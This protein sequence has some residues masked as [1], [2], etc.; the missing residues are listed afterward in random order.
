MLETN[1]GLTSRF[2]KTIIF[3]D[4]NAEQLSEIFLNKAKKDRLTLDAEAEKAMRSYF[5]SLCRNKGRNFG[6]AREVNNY[7]AK[8][9][10]NQSAR[11]RKA[12]ELPDFDKMMFCQLL[13]ED[14]LI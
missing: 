8:V 4:Y 14:M 5:D 3:E 10:I 1:S 13:A 9:K 6:N 11:L 2:N 7:F 12:M